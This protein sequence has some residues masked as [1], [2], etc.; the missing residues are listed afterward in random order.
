MASGKYTTGN[1]LVA[2]IPSA[3]QDVTGVTAVAS[4]VV[5]GK[6]IVDSSGNILHGSLVIQY[7]YT[8]SSAPSASLG[9]A[10]DIYLQTES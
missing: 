1:V 6:D 4:D 5:S 9:V 8:G 2:A 10:G 3:Y 7:Y